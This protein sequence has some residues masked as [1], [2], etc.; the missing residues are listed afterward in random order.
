MAAKYDYA[1]VM[2]DDGAGGPDRLIQYNPY[3]RTRPAVNPERPWPGPQH[4]LDH[5]SSL[6]QRQGRA[7]GGSHP[8]RLVLMQQSTATLEPQQMQPSVALLDTS[9]RTRSLNS[10][11]CHQRNGN[12]SYLGS[13]DDALQDDI[14]Y[15]KQLVLLQ[16]W[17]RRQ[18][19]QGQPFIFCI[20][21]PRATIQKHPLTR[22]CVLR[23]RADGGLGGVA[24]H[25]DSCWFPSS[26]S[27]VHKKPEVLFTNN[28][29]LI[30]DFAKRKYCCSKRRPCPRRAEGLNHDRLEGA[31]CTAAAAQPQE[32]AD[33]LARLHYLEEARLRGAGAS[34]R[35]HCG[36]T[37][38]SPREILLEAARA[39]DKEVAKAP[40]SAATFAVG[41]VTYEQGS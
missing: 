22:E 7:E 16:W 5:L 27:K 33:H 41:Y 11:G 39:A 31:A 9:C 40:P 21:N 32:L 23:P 26:A 17:L 30:N 18:E 38:V 24:C 20:E 37:F 6:L 15:A 1:V 25:F 28:M 10:Q 3:W 19:E 4:E 14:D 2:V 35:R 12:N 36:A 8:R 34:M 29:E 13:T